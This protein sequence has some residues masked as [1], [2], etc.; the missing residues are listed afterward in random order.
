MA[1]APLMPDVPLRDDVVNPRP[2]PLASTATS[3]EW[4]TRTPRPWPSRATT[5]TC[6]RSALPS[7]RKR[8]PVRSR[9][10]SC[11]VTK[12]RKSSSVTTTMHT[13]TR[14]RL[15]SRPCA[16]R[17]RRPRPRRCALG[18]SAASAFAAR[19][20]ERSG[21]PASASR[22]ASGL[23][24]ARRHGLRAATAATPVAAAAA[25]SVL[26]RRAALVS[27]STSAADGRDGDAAGLRPDALAGPPE[28]PRNA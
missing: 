3:P 1:G 14:P 5:A 6:R 28:Q 26:A 9:A 11:W 15:R 20:T 21:L 16:R 19:A 25:G 17:P 2:S 18:A 10:K 12:V 8:R 27:Q 4:S 23:R 13:A 22:P 24:V 7:T